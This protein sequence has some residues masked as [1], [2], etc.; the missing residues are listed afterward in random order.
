MYGFQA[1][2]FPMQQEIFAVDDKTRGA[3]VEASNQTSQEL[4]P[5]QPS[6]SGF[7]KLGALMHSIQTIS[8]AHLDKLLPRNETRKEANHSEIF[9]AS[10][11]EADNTTNSS[12]SVELSRWRRPSSLYVKD[13]N[14]FGG[15]NASVS[16]QEQSGAIEENRSLNPQLSKDE[17]QDI[18]AGKR[19]G[20]WRKTKTGCDSCPVF[21]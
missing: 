15:G 18:L 8:N 4:A 5:A 12:E 10:P 1:F 17:I 19:V 20:K 3:L 14:G 2:K 16:P 6:S 7:A 21:M 13:A 9:V 11:M